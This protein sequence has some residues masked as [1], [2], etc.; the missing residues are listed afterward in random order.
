VPTDTFTLALLLIYS[1]AV[2]TGISI[3]YDAIMLTVDLAFPKPPERKGRVRILS[4]D[5]KAAN[6]ALYQTDKGFCVRDAVLILTD[7]LFFAVSAA[8]LVVLIMHVNHGKVRA[9]SLVGAVFGFGLYRKTLS[10]PLTHLARILLRVLK[11]VLKTVLLPVL[12][13]VLRFVRNVKK[14][15]GD[16]KA[17]KSALRAIYAMEQSEKKREEKRKNRQ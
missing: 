1:L 15:Y 12:R 10:K 2:G 4:P 8:A 9:F 6:E 5:P 13:P 3:F 17:K 14:R 11:R 16:K 7:I